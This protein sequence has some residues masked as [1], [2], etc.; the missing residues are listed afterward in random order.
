MTNTNRTNER[1]EGLF[2]GLSLSRA[3]RVLFWCHVNLTH[4]LK[5]SYIVKYGNF[6]SWQPHKCT[7]TFTCHLCL[8]LCVKGNKLAENTQSVQR[9]D[10]GLSPVQTCD[11]N[12]AISLS[13]CHLY[14]CRLHLNC[15][16]KQWQWSARHDI[17]WPQSGPCPIWRGHTSVCHVPRVDAEQSCGQCGWSLHPRTTGSK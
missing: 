2:V 4:D 15:W 13:L 9:Q 10:E 5:A 3:W 6:T 14:H 7:V 11:V 8:Q 16:C 1:K 12:H 17:L